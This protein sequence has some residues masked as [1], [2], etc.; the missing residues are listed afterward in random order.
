MSA[1]AVRRSVAWPPP[2]Y[3][4]RHTRNSPCINCQVCARDVFR[5]QTA[6]PCREAL[7]KANP[8]FCPIRAKTR[9]NGAFS[10]SRPARNAGKQ[11]VSEIWID[12]PELSN[13]YLSVYLFDKRRFVLN[14]FHNI[15]WEKPCA[16]FFDSAVDAHRFR[17]G[18]QI[19]SE[20]NVSF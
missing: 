12:K 1:A 9:E 4:G 14:I 3:L 15:I 8:L 11:R 17:I 19:V 10:V 7:K 6:R 16:F 20:G 5:S 18:A 13:A 2:P